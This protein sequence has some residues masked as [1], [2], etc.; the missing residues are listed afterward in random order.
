MLLRSVL[1]A[2]AALLLTAPAGAQQRAIDAGTLLCGGAV[3]PAKPTPTPLPIPR[4]LLAPGEVKCVFDPVK[5]SLPRQLYLVRPQ[6][7]RGARV[8]PD[9]I[10]AWEVFS[11]I[12]VAAAFL[13]GGYSSGLEDMP[14]A[15]GLGS[16]LLLGGNENMIVLRP[17]KEKGNV[18]AAV[19][20]LELEFVDCEPSTAC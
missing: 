12:S 6:L 15:S 20:V 19:L 4:P 13:S 3:P 16:D 5:D 7:A 17:R 18:A 11:G 8:E 9:A 10:L 1:F 2:A 14:I